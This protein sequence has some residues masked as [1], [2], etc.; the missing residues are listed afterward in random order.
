LAG[1][2]LPVFKLAENLRH[3]PK[4]LV[5]VEGFA[6]L[7]EA[8]RAVPLFSYPTRTGRRT[9]CPMDKPTLSPVGRASLLVV[10]VY[11]LVMGAQL[12]CTPAH[13]TAAPDPL[14]VEPLNQEE[15]VVDI[16]GD[17]GVPVRRGIPPKPSEWQKRPPCPKEMGEREINGAC[18]F[19][20]HPD[21]MK[22]PCA[23]PALEHGEF[24]WRAIAKLQRE[25]SSVGR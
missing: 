20:I 23:S 6:H 16:R 1:L 19:R 8:A 24:C 2:R 14:V 10:A 17:G 4:R 15:G 11:A 12:R 22:P 9:V 13:R 25:P 3:E 21:D 18:Y 7:R 5:N